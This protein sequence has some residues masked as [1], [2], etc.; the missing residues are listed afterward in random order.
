MH[1]KILNMA[2]Y[3]TEDWSRLLSIVD[4]RH[5]F[6]DTWEKWHQQYQKSKKQ[7]RTQGFKVKDVV[8][9]IDDLIRFCFLKGIK[10][11]CK[12]RSRFVSQIN[13]KDLL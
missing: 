1:E 4:D 3:R 6:H 7:L 13:I 12:A 5:V 8:V 11:D 10:N 2:F 9:N